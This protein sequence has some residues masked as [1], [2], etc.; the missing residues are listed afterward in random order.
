[1]IVTKALGVDVSGKERYLR[2]GETGLKIC[3]EG[4]KEGILI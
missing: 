4:D 1:M 2:G 3:M